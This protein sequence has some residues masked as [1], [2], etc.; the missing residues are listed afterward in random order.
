MSKEGMEEVYI[1][2]R[3]LRFVAV[4]SLALLACSS[5]SAAPT[6]TVLPSTVGQ[7]LGQTAV[8]ATR[9]P[10]VDL[11]PTGTEL[12]H[13]Q[14]ESTLPVASP[15]PTPTPG[16]LLGANTVTPPPTVPSE[17]YV[18]VRIPNTINMQTECVREIPFD[19]VI[20][21]SR[22]MCR[23]K[24]RIDCAFEGKP[25]GG[26]DQPIVY[27]VILEIDAELDGEL[28]QATPARPKGWL[29]TYLSLDGSIVQYYTGYPPQATNPC[30]ES[31]PCR[32]PSTD[33]IP[34]PFDFEDGN[35]ITTPWTF[36][37]HL[38]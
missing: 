33:V 31:S 12:A 36:I 35:T 16:L 1:M 28:L 7:A 2:S 3:A 9:V 11:E 37:L 26:E 20:E 38:R 22:T 14:P 10:L 19:L 13:S 25:L 15:T 34:L 6:E 29:D 32:T 30:P 18:Q 24:G 17:G 23:G 21:G 27:H 5:P 8:A 4:L